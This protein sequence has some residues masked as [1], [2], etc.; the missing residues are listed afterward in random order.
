VE[1]AHLADTEAFDFK[2]LDGHSPEAAS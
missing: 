1:L 2:D